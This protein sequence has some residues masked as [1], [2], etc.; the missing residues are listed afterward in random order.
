MVSVPVAAWGVMGE[1]P[2]CDDCS[3]PAGCGLSFAVG[4]VLVAATLGRDDF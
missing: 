3:A 1:L 2:S 4:G